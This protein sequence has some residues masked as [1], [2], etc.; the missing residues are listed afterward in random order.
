MAQLIIGLGTADDTGNDGHLNKH[1]TKIYIYIFLFF[2]MVDLQELQ[3][4]INHLRSECDCMSEK[5]T[6]LTSGKGIMNI[7]K[8][9]RAL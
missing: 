5:V 3:Q 8:Q 6:E 1:F 7:I 9:E 4:D 2:Q